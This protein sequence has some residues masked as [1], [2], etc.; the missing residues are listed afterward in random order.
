MYGSLKPWK[1]YCDETKIT[2]G[3]HDSTSLLQLH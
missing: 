2:V 3:R 1:A